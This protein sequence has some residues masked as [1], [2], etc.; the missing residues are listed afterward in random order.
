[1]DDTT[2]SP[3]LDDEYLRYGPAGGWLWPPD[4][5]SAWCAEYN[6]FT[7]TGAYSPHAR[8]GDA[9]ADIRLLVAPTSRSFASQCADAAVTVQ[10]VTGD[11]S[12]ADKALVLPE[13]LRTYLGQ[14]RILTMQPDAA[15]QLPPA[16][17]PCRKWVSGIRLSCFN[18]SFVPKRA[19]IKNVTRS[20]ASRP[21]GTSIARAQSGMPPPP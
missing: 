11:C 6:F 4:R 14:A 10:P 21:T 18:G 13:L 1:M 5:G 15:G 17:P 12:P 7:T 3:E 16:P 9:W 2:W 8:A 20:T 19:Q